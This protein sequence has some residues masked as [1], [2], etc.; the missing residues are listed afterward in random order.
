MLGE[1]L[2]LLRAPDLALEQRQLHDVEIL[3]EVGDLVEVLCLDLAAR[4]AHSAG[5]H[6]RLLEQQL[7][8][9]QELIIPSIQYDTQIRK[10]KKSIAK[11]PLPGYRSVSCNLIIVYLLKYSYLID[12]NVMR[13]DADLGQLLYQPL[14][15]VE[16]EELGDANAHEGRRV[17]VLELLVHLLD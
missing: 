3:V 11:G 15:L 12:N 5:R 1:R 14:R 16:R 4:L 9:V 7:R 8:K 13:V 2:H 17:R 6:P 10:I